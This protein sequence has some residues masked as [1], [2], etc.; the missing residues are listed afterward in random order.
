MQQALQQQAQPSALEEFAAA[1]FD[2]DD[3]SSDETI[4]SEDGTSVRY[5]GN[6]FHY[7]LGAMYRDLDGFVRGLLVFSAISDGTQS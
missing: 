4:F 6:S 5:H 2:Q 7:E 3:I 1:L